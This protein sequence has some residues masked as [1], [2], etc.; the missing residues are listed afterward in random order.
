MNDSGHQIDIRE[1]W[2]ILMRRKVYLIIPVMIIPLVAFAAG[3]FMPPVYQSSVTLLIDESKILPPS[4]ERQLEGPRSYSRAT[5]AERQGALYSQITSTKYLRRLIAILDVPIP[6]DVRFIADQTK[7]NIRV[8]LSSNNLLRIGFTASNPIR[9][10]KMAKTLADVFIEE[11]LAQELAGVRSNIAF[12]EEQMDLYFEKL[13]TAENKLKSFRQQLIV[14]T[15][16]ED[17]SGLNIQQI[18]SAVEAID[19]E[20]LS[21]EKKQMEY[22]GLL[23]S[24]GLEVNRINLPAELIP[25]KN[26]LL[27]NI[28]TLTDLLTRYSWRDPKVLSLNEESK[29]ILINLNNRIDAYVE[30]EYSGESPAV[31]ETIGKFISGNLAIE[32]NRSKRKTLNQSIVKIKTRLSDNPDSEVTLNRLQSEIDNYRTLYDLFVQ[33]SQFAAIDQSAR[34]IEA[35]AK[36]VVIKPASLPLG[37]QSP[38]KRKLFLMGIIVGLTFGA[39]IIILFE[40]LDSSFKKIE[41]IEGFTGMK[42]LGTIPR[43]DLPFGSRIKGKV[44]YI[45]GA[46]IS[47]VLVVWI[48]F[49]RSKVSG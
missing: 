26:R 49:L 3:Y 48:L 45:I 7:N 41:D 22:R 19:I 16:G 37:P 21:L 12:S 32:F 1:Y 14:N 36:Y 17:T 34:K 40:I 6:P 47:F 9:A 44:P 20:V 27:S 2:A 30:S 5:T 10:Q 25:E 28:S 4:V 31:R 38:N 39:G 23:L 24:E 13:T 33:H 42:V 35:E 11:S 8:E 46:S 43:L 29:N 15:V 18:A